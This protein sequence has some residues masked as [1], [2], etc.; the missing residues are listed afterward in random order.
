MKTVQ[1]IEESKVEK[2]LRR[3]RDHKIQ[4][5]QAKQLKE[6]VQRSEL[7]HKHISM[8]TTDKKAR[9]HKEE[10]KGEYRDASDPK[11]EE[12]QR[13]ARTLM[14]SMQADKGE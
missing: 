4:A 11:F 5:L 2:M 7:K 6:Q 10:S 14:I 13:E 3:Y 9:S 12:Y 1:M 8:K